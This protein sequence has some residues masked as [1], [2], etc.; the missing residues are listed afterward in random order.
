MSAEDDKPPAYP[1]DTA[2]QLGF[3]AAVTNIPAPGAVHD[4]NRWILSYRDFV[5]QTTSQGGMFTV[6]TFEPFP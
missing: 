1:A 5:P 2:P 6:P 3:T 4:D